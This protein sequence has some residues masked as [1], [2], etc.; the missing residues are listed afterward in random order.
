MSRFIFFVLLLAGIAV[1]NSFKSYKSVPLDNKR[2]NLK[3]AETHHKIHL[4]EVA[5]QAKARQEILHPVHKEEVKKVEG[6][7]VILSTP[8]L[9]RGHALYAKCV[10]CHGKRG[11][12]KRSQNAPAIG[13]QHDWYLTTQL[14]NMKSGIRVNKKMG[15][16]ISKLSGKDFSDLANYVSKLPKTWT[17]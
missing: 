13:G 12:G 5:S 15:P 1:L 14:N 7:L 4:K 10:V 16:Y 11:E 17:K 8:E 2:F 9:E 3:S 6:P